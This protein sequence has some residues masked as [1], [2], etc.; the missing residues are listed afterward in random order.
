M[1]LNGSKWLKMAQYGCKRLKS[2]PKDPNDL[3]KAQIG[4]KRLKQ[5]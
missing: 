4:F 3:K 2:D 5:A 1:A